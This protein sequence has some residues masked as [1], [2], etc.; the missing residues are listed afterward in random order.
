MERDGKLVAFEGE[1]MSI[2]EAKRR[3]VYLAA[4]DKP[5]EKPA[6]AIFVS[7]LTSFTWM[8][9]PGSSITRSPDLML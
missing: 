8:K 3:G 7:S 1:L 2:E 6:K 4:V 9:L 5:A